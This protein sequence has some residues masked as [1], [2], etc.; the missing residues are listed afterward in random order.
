VP[1]G[2]P[3]TGQ[4]PQQGRPAGPGGPSRSGRPAGPF[5]PSTEN[6]PPVSREEQSY[7]REPDLL[8]HRDDDH[9]TEWASNAAGGYDEDG[10]R[11]RRHD[12]RAGGGLLSEEDRRTI[13]KQKIFRRSR[14]T[15]YVL[16]G[17]AII[18]PIVGF[19]VM[20]QIV[21]VPDPKLVAATLNQPVTIYY[22]DGSLMDKIGTDENGHQLIQVSDL[23]KLENIQHAVMAAEDSTFETNAGVDLKAILRTAYHQA[24]GGSGGA[25]TITQEYIKQA[26]N[27]GFLGSLPLK[28]KIAEMVK[29]YKMSRTVDKADIMA[30]YLNIVYFGRHAYGIG[31]ASE[32]FFGV[33]PDKLTD[34]Q[35]ALLAGMIQSPGRANS[36]KYQLQRYNYVMGN[37]AKNG[38]LKPGEQGTAMPAPNPPSSSESSLPW[39]RK[40]IVQQVKAEL[41]AN[42]LDMDTLARYGAKVYTTIQPGAQQTAEQ[43]VQQAMAKDA[44][45]TNGGPMSFQGKP[46]MVDGKQI[47]ATQA[48]ALV[49]IDPTTGG[50]IAWYGG[51]D[52]NA[53]QYDMADT[54]HQPGSS[55]K[56]YVFAS[57]LQNDPQQ[58]GLNSIYDGS[59]SLTIA[60]HVVHNSEGEG[61]GPVSV[62]TAMTK[63]I[64]TVFYAMGV[65][66]GVKKVQATAW[67]LGI[68]QQIRNTG[69]SGPSMVTSLQDLN[70]VTEGGISIGQYPVRPRDQAQGYATLANYGNYIPSHFISKVTDDTG[71]TVYT[72]AQPAKP[73]FGDE[74]TSQSIAH[75]VIDSMTDV[76]S[77][78]TLSLN[79]NRPVAAKTGTQ[80]YNDP[81]TGA[82]LNGWDSDAWMCGFTPSVV[83]AVW[84]GHYDRTAPIFGVG[85]NTQAAGSHAPYVMFGHDDPGLI[86]KNYMDGVLGNSPPQQFATYNDI[87]GQW[88]FMTNSAVTQAPPSQSSQ[89]NNPG[90]GGGGGDTTTQQTTQQQPTTTDTTTNSGGGGGHCGLL[91]PTSGNPGGGNPIGHGNTGAPNPGG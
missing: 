89:P 27:P 5:E 81:Q 37:M 26:T 6:L 50:I 75:T 15:L 77:A 19:F 88:N 64:N 83:T 28:T 58:E 29:A 80:G 74:A 12:S 71:A 2:R 31:A 48:A 10:P 49:S 54:P 17:L 41:A 39:D 67:Q 25:S 14:R 45:Y 56:P 51:N 32:A 33:T 1:N 22:A 35:A 34:Q 30:S 78:D 7:G 47:K 53:T 63:S 11:D 65:N 86:W 21:S 24:T 46:V 36:T 4:R 59:N 57:A 9:A 72:F 76:A 68:P 20:Y 18:A 44:A 90:G 8:T 62:K 42:K 87:N 73:A 84:I 70:G 55:F 23:P 79:G 82:P 52:P 3:P 91:C 66:T 60:G 40:L 61:N 69:G 16:V 43:S 85:N 38:W 13:L